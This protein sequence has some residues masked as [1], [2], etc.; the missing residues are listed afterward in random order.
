MLLKIIIV[1]VAS[2]L[3]ALFY[4][5]GGSNAGTKWR[6]MGVSGVVCLAT[7]I[8]VHPVGLWAYL[9]LIPCFG[10]M[11]GALSTYRYFLPKPDDYTFPYYAL[12]GFF[13]ALSMVFFAWATG[14]W[15][16]FWIRVAVC[17]AGV[18]AWSAW[19]KRDWIEEG[20]RGFLVV[21]TLPLLLL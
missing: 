14:H 7:G 10:A 20:G 15:I 19:I 5:L 12:H 17:T 11:F 21:G 16:G 18:S 4:R 8:L 9:S 6:D 13:V 2:A 3:S 1:L